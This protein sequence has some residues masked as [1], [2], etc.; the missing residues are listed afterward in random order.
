MGILQWIKVN[1]TDPDYYTT[2]YNTL[3]VPIHL[4]LL[5][6]IAYRHPLQ[7]TKVLELIALSFEMETGLDA[8]IAVSSL[9]VT[10]IKLPVGP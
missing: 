6:E 7:R 2:S 3:C 10:L 9:E 4:E 1:F 5:R 8:V